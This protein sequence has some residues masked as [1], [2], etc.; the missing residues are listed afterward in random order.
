LPVDDQQK[1]VA[2]EPIAVI[3]E[4]NGKHEAIQISPS[5]IAEN[6]MQFDQVF[7]GGHIRDEEEQT[8]WIEE[9]KKRNRPTVGQP[10]REENDFSYHAV[11]SPLDADEFII[12][13]VNTTQD[14]KA[15]AHHLKAMLQDVQRKT[16][17]QALLA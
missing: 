6:K 14:P 17:L 8:V 11:A 9:K 16:K 12:E 13:L 1:V 5:K 2:D 4:S 15:V 7:A 3:H 10:K